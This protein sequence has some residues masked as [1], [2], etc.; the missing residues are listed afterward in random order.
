MGRVGVML[1]FEQK[2]GSHAAFGNRA[3]DSESVQFP[4]RR[5]GFV[6][7]RKIEID[8]AESALGFLIIARGLVGAPDGELYIAAHRSTVFFQQ[9]CCFLRTIFFEQRTGI[10]EVGIADKKRVGKIFAEIRQCSQRLGIVRC[11]QVGLAQVVGNVV[12]QFAGSGFGAVERVDGFAIIVIK[13]V[14]IADYQPR[15]GSGV[16]FGMTPGIGFD[17]GIGGGA[18]VLQ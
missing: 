2:I 5:I 13:G 4:S 17:P 7:V 6:A 12:S 16:F 9:R 10:D 1:G 14:G 18:S 11:V 8:I 15:Q 3:L